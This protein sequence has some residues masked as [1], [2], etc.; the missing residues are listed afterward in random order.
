MTREARRSF[1]V[2]A[3]SIEQVNFAL[4]LIADRMDEMEGRRGS[5]AFKADV[6]LNNNKLR[7]VGTAIS[8]DDA[9]IFNQLQVAWPIGSIFITVLTTNPADS[10]GFGVWTAFGAGKMLVGVDAADVDF[11]TAEETGGAKTVNLSH[12]HSTPAHVHPAGTTV[13]SGTGVI[14]NDGTGGG[15]TSGSSGSATQTIMNPYITAYF[16]KRTA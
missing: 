13:Q 1:R 6:N 14:V 4:G 11:D 2:S 8:S 10:L 7:N 15:G 5:P 9:V 12:T 16:W 3:L